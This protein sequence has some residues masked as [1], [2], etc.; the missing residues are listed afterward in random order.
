MK[1][2]LRPFSVRLSTIFLLMVFVG[3]VLWFLTPSRAD[4]QA[5]SRL[6]G[7]WEVRLTA[8]RD[9]TTETRLVEYKESELV[10]TAR[11]ASN[12]HL[13]PTVRKHYWCVRNGVL[14]DG[15]QHATPRESEYKIIWSDEDN[16][17]T[18]DIGSM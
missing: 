10:G 7:T 17:A 15:W 9:A 12:R 2:K 5:E 14:I 4:L 1:L 11:R 16:F 18:R 3:I 8:T 13:G 6:I